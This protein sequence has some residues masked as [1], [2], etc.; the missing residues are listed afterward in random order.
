MDL[1]KRNKIFTNTNYPNTRDRSISFSGIHL[2][3]N[4]YHPYTI[5]DGMLLR[6]RRYSFDRTS[7]LETFLLFSL[8]RDGQ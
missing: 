2:Q 4:C 8:K 3:K 1:A 5:V 6:C 7:I